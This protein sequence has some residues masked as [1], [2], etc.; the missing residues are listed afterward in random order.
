MTAA[1]LRA[2]LTLRLSTG[3]V[4]LLKPG[5]RYDPATGSVSEAPEGQP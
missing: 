2:P 3:Q 1:A 5:Q 4:V